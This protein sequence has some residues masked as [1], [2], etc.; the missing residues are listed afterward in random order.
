MHE[1]VKSGDHSSVEAREDEDKVHDLVGYFIL[2]W[3][4]LTSLNL[5]P[6]SS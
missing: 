2:C 3:A 1:E 5:Q 4:K 6:L